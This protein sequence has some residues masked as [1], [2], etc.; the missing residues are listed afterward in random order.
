LTKNYSLTE[1]NLWSAKFRV[2]TL[3]RPEGGAGAP[4]SHARRVCG[5]KV[6][7]RGERGVYQ[8]LADM[9]CERITVAITRDFLDERPI[10]ALLDPYN[11]TGSTRHVRFN[12]SRADRWDTGG[13]PPKNHVNWVVLDSDWE[14][15]F[16][17]VGPATF[18]VNPHGAIAAPAGCAALPHLAARRRDSINSL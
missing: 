1:N 4:I 7:A 3:R 12:T 10:K 2:N 5:T 15:E 14:A 17:R 6:D 11:H 16:C 13:P 8:E 9:A 18:G